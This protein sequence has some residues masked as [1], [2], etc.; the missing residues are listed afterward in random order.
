MDAQKGWAAEKQELLK[1]Q[2]QWAIEKTAFVAAKDAWA[3]EKDE[4]LAL[5]KEMNQKQTAWVDRKAE[6]DR[7]IA[8]W[9]DDSRAKRARIADLELKL[10]TVKSELQDARLQAGKCEIHAWSRVTC[11]NLP[12]FGQHGLYRY[13]NRSSLLLPGFGFLCQAASTKKTTTSASDSP[14]EAG[15]L[16]SY[17]R[18]MWA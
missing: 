10:S 2:Q 14:T 1:A 11:P 8:L 6:Y 4:L 3:A 15:I 16:H 7:A 9:M 17:M 18:N 5:Q 12:Y 13:T